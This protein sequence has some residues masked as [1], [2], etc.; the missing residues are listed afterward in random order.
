MRQPAVGSPIQFLHPH[1]V[2]A[3]CIVHPSLTAQAR[4]GEKHQL[5]LQHDAQSSQLIFKVLAWL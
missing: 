1:Q 4:R 5:S 3:S 2:H